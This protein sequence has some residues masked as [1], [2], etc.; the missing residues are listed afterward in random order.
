MEHVAQRV[1]NVL[2]LCTGNSGRS[3]IAESVLNRVGFG[4]FNA[5]S[6]GSHPRP[7]PDPM[8]I[9]ELRRQNY[10]TDGLRSKDWNEFTQAASPKVDF[11]FTVCDNARGE[12]CPVWPGHPMTAHWGMEDP[13]AF[14]GPE[15]QRRW[16]IRR[17]IRE[18]ENRLK[19]FIALPLPL[20]AL[21]TLTLQARL[22]EIGCRLEKQRS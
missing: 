6:A 1:S 12:V 18:L 8:V 3:I 7:V 13:H 14:A 9:D 22:D 5:Y 10:P 17:L 11:V 19:I 16:L 15:E 20:D 2:F 4:R 21:D